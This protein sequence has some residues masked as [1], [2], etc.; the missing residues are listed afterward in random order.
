[1]EKERNKCIETEKIV[2]NIKN[3]ICIRKKKY[4]LIPEGEESIWC[5]KETSKIN[6][7]RLNGFRSYEWIERCKT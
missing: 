2:N 1:M 5:N 7:G 3:H 4:K 6:S